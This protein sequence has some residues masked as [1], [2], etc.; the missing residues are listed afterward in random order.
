[1][2]PLANTI[3]YNKD[4]GSNSVI[5]NAETYLKS[6]MTQYNNIN[7]LTEE[8]NQIIKQTLEI[9]NNHKFPF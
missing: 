3:T 8:E 1:M 7:K 4:T 2:R 9:L 6:F 5:V